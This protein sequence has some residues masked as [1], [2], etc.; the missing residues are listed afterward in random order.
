MVS[1]VSP[2]G[3]T[4]DEDA[5]ADVAGL[6]HAVDHLAAEAVTDDCV[7]QSFCHR[8]AGQGGEHDVDGDP[9]IAE[10]RGQGAGEP[11]TAILLVR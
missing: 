3:K 6:G 1:R 4:Q 10:R 5:S 8:G 7:W 2:E 11:M 9:V